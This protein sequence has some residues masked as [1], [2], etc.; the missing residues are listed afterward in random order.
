MSIIELN[1]KFYNPKY[2]TLKQCK[3]C[4]KDFISPNRFNQM[5]CS[6]KCSSMTL[7]TNVSTIEKRKATCRKKY[8]ADSPFASTSIQSKIKQTCL[9]KF[10]VDNPSKSI[11]IIDKIKQANL[12]KYGVEWSFQSEIVKDKIKQVCLAKYGVDNPS[13]S[14][15]IKEKK[16]QVCQAKYG[17]DNVFQ[18]DEIKEKIKLYYI[19]T[20]GD[21]IWHHSQLNSV[22]KIKKEKS[23][24]YFYTS[25]MT[26]N[27]LQGLVKPLFTKEE[28]TNRNASYLFN[29]LKCNTDFEGNLKMDSN[30]NDIPRC[31]TCFPKIFNRSQA[32][33]DIQSFLEQFFTSDQIETNNRTILDGKE[34]DFYIPHK[35]IAIEFNGLFWHSENFGNKSEKYH[36]DKTKLCE[37]RNI[38]LIQIFESEWIHKQEI[39]K[40]KLKHIMGMND[41]TKIYARNCV[42]Q[43]KIPPTVK[44]EFLNQYH[45]QGKDNSSI[46][47]GAYHENKLVAIMTFGKPRVALG[48]KTKTIQLG[49]YE[50]LRFATSTNVVGVASK[51]LSYF[52][53]TYNPSKIV[54]YADRRYTHSTNNVYNSIGFTKISETTPNYWYFKIGE[55][56]IQHRF[57]FRKSELLKKLEFFDPSL[58]E[59][60]NMTLNGFD[61]IWDCGNLKYERVFV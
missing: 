57:N 30:G 36:L 38:R 10:G 61:R 33:I 49:E 40:S 22:K 4:N 54:S 6:G 28:Y 59:W 47:I 48:R 37:S 14:N 19:E 27:R 34:L 21:K 25:L 29:C 60:Q 51:L 15:I 2:N 26:G 56:T 41:N 3:R 39:V 52:I 18:S 50:L 24:D 35:N 13:K 16:K 11:E 45:I 42:I 43:N 8:G 1:G 9:D 20:Y 12:K 58:T 5:Y 44:N 53:K 55:T 17:V 32:E 31:P 23:V 7:A 46:R